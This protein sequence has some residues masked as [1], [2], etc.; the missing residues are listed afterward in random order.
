[1][2]NS[3]NAITFPVPPLPLPPAGKPVTDFGQIE[4]AWIN[5]GMPFND[6]F[7]VPGYGSFK[8]SL[9]ANQ[10]QRTSLDNGTNIGD[11]I[12]APGELGYTGGVNFSY[13]YNTL[14]TY[15][16]WPTQTGP[17]TYTGQIQLLRNHGNALN[18]FDYAV[19]AV[20]AVGGGA[21]IGAAIAGAGAGAGAAAAGSASSDTALSTQDAA[22]I[23]SDTGYTGETATTGGSGIGSGSSVSSTTTATGTTASDTLPGD[24]AT[25]NGAPVQIPDTVDTTS[26]VTVDTGNLP[27]T[28]DNFTPPEPQ[29]IDVTPQN[30]DILTPED[31]AAI[32]AGNSSLLPQ[33]LQSGL[34]Q[35]S[36]GLSLAKMIGNAIAAI[37]GKT[38]ALSDGTQ[39]NP[40]GAVADTA[41]GSIGGLALMGLA[42]YLLFQG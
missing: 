36:S 7:N 18:D 5:A 22:T 10:S 32:G 33:G 17:G 31:Q 12:T 38:N 4:T 40:G 13:V 26:S 8:A 41:S 2:P 20:I 9:N 6:Y 39:T 30:V 23:Y 35:A 24:L 34:Q 1:M 28:I 25:T 29:P 42:A 15:D 37:T 21:V 11:N 14:T 27:S 3:P 19:L 16:L